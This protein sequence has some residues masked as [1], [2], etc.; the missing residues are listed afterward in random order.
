[1]LRPT[2]DRVRETLFN[3]LAPIIGG[4]KCLDC[5]AGTGVL[6]FEALSRGAADVVMIESDRA[7]ADALQAQAARL[8]TDAAH[9]VRTDAMSWL[10][11]DGRAFDII[12]LDPPFGSDLAAQACARILNGGHLAP[13]GVVYVETAHGWTPPAGY[14]I[15]KQGKA[16]Q[17][18]YMLIEGLAAGGPGH[19]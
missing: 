12:F 14:A 1:M 10:D 15:R 9:I 5:F 7:L 11:S 6:G 3:W 8:G 16:G 4:A 17:V 19:Q 13:G 18:Q 2:P